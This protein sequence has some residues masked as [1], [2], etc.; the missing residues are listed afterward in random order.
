MNFKYFFLFL[1]V[2]AFISC[3]DELSKI[4]FSIQPDAD[5][6]DI[7]PDTIFLNNR[8]ETYKVD[9][10]YALTNTALLGNLTDKT[11]GETTCDFM[12]QIYCNDNFKVPANEIYHDS[13][14]YSTITL[15]YQ[16]Y[17]GNEN[18]PMQASVYQLNS[19][20]NKE[21]NSNT[22]PSKYCNKSILLGRKSYIAQKKYTSSSGA[23]DSVQIKLNDSFTKTFYDKLKNHSEIFASND[24][25][26]QFF[27]GI[28]VTNNSG[29]GSILKAHNIALN[30]YYIHSETSMVWDTAKSKTDSVK[31]T[32]LSKQNLSFQVT[33]VTYLVNHY[34]HNQLPIPGPTDQFTY[35]KSP[36]GLFN[37]IKIPMSILASKVGKNKL[38]GAKL[39]INTERPNPDNTLF[40]PPS[41]MMLIKE[42]ELDNFFRTKAVIDSKKHAYAQYNSSTFQYTFS[43]IS[44]IL[45]E[46]LNSDGSVKTGSEEVSFALVPVSLYQDSST[47]A[48]TLKHLHQ[49][50]AVK[51]LT[52]PDKIYIS[53]VIAK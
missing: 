27:P 46:Y 49:P 18:E 17:I 1:G 11:Y 40:S 45:S 35:I 33:P 20:L 42:S 14:L 22:P 5:K 8:I 6:L 3:S 26:K 10:M 50:T 13:I 29:S 37:R 41:A 25:F 28:Y 9:S 34:T 19:Q 30:L 53:L 47:G 4:G 23:S 21:I 39:V 48:I 51:I 24:A 52:S 32:T 38:N 43:N 36:A 7:T 15:L 12:A 44:Q 16:D 2:L 31:V